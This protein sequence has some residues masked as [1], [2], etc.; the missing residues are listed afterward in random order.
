MVFCIVTILPNTTLKINNDVIFPHSTLKW[1][2]NLAIF[3]YIF[4]KKK[5]SRTKASRLE[6]LKGGS[7]SP[8]SSNP[9]PPQTVALKNA[10][11][12]LPVLLSTYRNLFQLTPGAL[13]PFPL[14]GVLSYS[15]LCGWRAP[16]MLNCFPL[17]H[18]A[19]LA[20][21]ELPF[22]GRLVLLSSRHEET[23]G[24]N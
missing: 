13:A 21:Q 3:S 9:C 6:F 5:A 19:D 7:K 23:I 14:A 2:L 10:H 1:P 4:K 8:R 24:K 11:W 22:I 15:L 16:V 18:L 17:W 12:R 20:F